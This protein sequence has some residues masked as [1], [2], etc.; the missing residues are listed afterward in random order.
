MQEKIQP[1]KPYLFVDISKPTGI[2]PNVEHN[3]TLSDLSAVFDYL[4][5]VNKTT[6]ISHLIQNIKSLLEKKEPV[7]PS[8]YNRITQQAEMFLHLINT[9]PTEIQYKSIASLQLIIQVLS[10]INNDLTDH[11]KESLT[12]LKEH[13]FSLL[14]KYEPHFYLNQKEI[15]RAFFKLKNESTTLTEL[16]TQPPLEKNSNNL[17]NNSKFSLPE[18]IKL[19][20]KQNHQRVVLRQIETTP[21]NIQQLLQNLN[22]YLNQIINNQIQNSQI[23]MHNITDTLNKLSTLFLF[24]HFLTPT[25]YHH[26]IMIFETAVNLIDNQKYQTL[27]D[28]QLTFLTKTI[29]K[30]PINLPVLET[31][32]LKLN[33]LDHGYLKSLLSITSLELKP[34]F[35]NVIEIV[36]NAIKSPKN[37]NL[38]TNQIFIKDLITKII[39]NRA[40]NR[41]DLLV[42]LATILRLGQLLIITQK[43]SLQFR[44]YLALMDTL[45]NVNYNFKETNL[46]IWT[47]LNRID[48]KILTNINS[49]SNTGTTK[50]TPNINF[51]TDQQ[52]PKLNSYNIN[53]QLI[54]PIIKQ[55][56]DMPIYKPNFEHHEILSVSDE[57]PTLIAERI[58]LLDNFNH[59]QPEEHINSFISNFFWFEDYLITG[60]GDGTIKIWLKKDDKYK[61]TGFFDSHLDQINDLKLYKNNLVSG[62]ADASIS[63][64][65]VINTR[66]LLKFKEHR[67]QITKLHIG[68]HNIGIGD[69]ELVMSSSLDGTVKIWG[70]KSGICL[71][72]LDINNS[73]VTDFCFQGEIII[74]SSKDQV[75]RVWDIINNN[76]LLNLKGHSAEITGLKIF[77]SLLI[78]ASKD[79]TIRLWDLENGNC[80]DVL[81]GHQGGINY[82]WI[83]SNQKLISASDDK[84]IRIW[85]LN[86]KKT[87]RILKGHTAEI[88]CI[89][90]NNNQLL[91]SG[92]DHKL[93]LWDLTTGECIEH[94][95]G[96]S[97]AKDLLK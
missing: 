78:S 88:T 54:D 68:W 56:N 13:L 90:T 96:S 18:L 48:F 86:N 49:I 62:S 87:S 42:L 89:Q 14:S 61:L 41:N 72:T 8:V 63:L 58:L 45:K 31:N 53:H 36:K 73:G 47:I 34:D 21:K 32:T 95:N 51:T 44:N 69:M 7:P 57:P 74:T 26:L 1:Q 19:T 2:K 75:I 10:D 97:L 52:L 55:K 64:W 92:K 12:K 77:G 9:L 40:S 22:L 81:Y 94:F 79:H 80:V 67:D 6:S 28:K 85:N 15:R 30:M 50:N 20:S 93:L 71:K 23:I 60:Y 59:H 4:I 3:K 24:S 91:S 83:D 65:D 38:E 33:F 37:N 46:N 29:P 84:T 82:L 35:E 17:K 39:K 70:A 16:L 66:H 27:I 5:S 25:L 76:C 11:Q 43:N